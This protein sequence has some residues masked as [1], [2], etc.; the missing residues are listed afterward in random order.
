MNAQLTQKRYSSSK[1]PEILARK[2]LLTM[3]AA[4]RH[5]VAATLEPGKWEQMLWQERLICVRDNLEKAES[6]KEDRRTEYLTRHKK[7]KNRQILTDLGT[8]WLMKRLRDDKLTLTDSSTGQDR[9]WCTTYSYL[10][11]PIPD[12]KVIS[13]KAI[14][15]DGNEHLIIAET[16]Y[17]DKT[18]TKEI[19][20]EKFKDMLYADAGNF[21]S[22]ADQWMTRPDKE[23][24]PPTPSASPK[25]G[26]KKN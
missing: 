11:R 19:A 6:R 23:L 13:K 1:D 24:D 7:Y 2:E 14:G 12:G 8:K 26:K 18:V 20:L 16:R 4:D 22:Q 17:A 3:N 5:A 9:W 25:S 21:M 15:E 10:V